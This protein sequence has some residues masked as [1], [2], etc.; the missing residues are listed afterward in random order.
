MVK[1][2]K[3]DYY[4][5]K[6]AIEHRTIN[7]FLYNK[8]YQLKYLQIIILGILLSSCSSDLITVFKDSKLDTQDFT[9]KNIIICPSTGEWIIVGKEASFT[10]LPE[11]TIYT[12]AFTKKLKELRPCINIIDQSRLTYSS[13]DLERSMNARKYCFNNMTNEDSTFFDSLSTT[14]NADYLIFF[15]SVEFFAAQRNYYQVSVVNKDSKLIMQLWDL[16]QYTMI[17]RAASSGSGSNIMQLLKD[18]SSN[19]ALENSFIEYIESL[20]KCVQKKE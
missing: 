10:A 2:H 17:Y 9:N 13:P 20:P 3:F 5:G 7:Y 19:N 4:S 18:E 1:I 14:F 16:R 15:E 11:V 8:E 6:Q 12:K